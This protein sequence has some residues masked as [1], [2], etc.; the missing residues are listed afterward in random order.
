MLPNTLLNR[1]LLRL[2]I[3]SFSA[4]APIAIIYAAV[5][6]ILLYESE[7]SPLLA[8]VPQ[9]LRF[10]APYLNDSLFYCAYA[11]S[12]FFALHS[13]NRYRIEMNDSK[14]GEE[15]IS[16]EERWKIWRGMLEST[17]EPEDWLGPWFTIAGRQG[18]VELDGVGRDNI[19]EVRSCSMQRFTDSAAQTDN[20]DRS[21]SRTR[22]ILDRSS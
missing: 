19:E 12:Y 16:S 6:L 3:Y 9:R 17:K 15:E 8:F 22:F 13:L 20:L 14:G 11:E 7:F 4:V 2:V 5:Y 1:S 18:R 21:S 10:L